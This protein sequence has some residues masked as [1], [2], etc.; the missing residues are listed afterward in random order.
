M[1]YQN[2]RKARRDVKILIG[3]VLVLVLYMAFGC[4]D[5]TG[6][7]EEKPVSCT[8]WVVDN[9]GYCPGVRYAREN[10]W[11]CSRTGSDF[12]WIYYECR[13]C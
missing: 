13:K 1:R 6:T 10:G 7:C 5:S 12:E 2:G 8:R 4:S 3:L 11:N 9:L